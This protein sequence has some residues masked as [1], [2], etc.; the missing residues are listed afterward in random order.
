MR[1]AG[2][3]LS[4]FALAVTLGACGGNGGSSTDTKDAGA[5]GQTGA[6]SLV[7]L[8]KSIGDE[9][10]E[11]SSAH[12][13]ITGKAAGQDITGDGD[14][15]FG[16]DDAA[17]SMDMTTP[18]GSISLVFLDGVLYV[19]L[20]QELQPGKPWLKIDSS[21]NSPVAKAL[22]TVNEQL[23]KNADP[24]AALKE[25]EKSGEITATKEEEL[26]GKKTKHYT[27]TVNVQKMADNQADPTQKKAMQDAIAAG[28]KDFPVDVW[29]DEEGL[30]ARFALDT[31]TPDG[32]G[33]MTSVKMQV[34]YTDWGKP[35]EITPPPADQVGELPA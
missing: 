22:S 26:D 21:S 28:M 24:R 35:V 2:I 3:V 30:P 34:D 17:L 1:K 10:A 6:M 32:S 5:N 18:Q 15:K 33:G 4:A 27:I 7:D 31:P 12:M 14:L 8:A 29:V 20:P 11:K 9:T 16:S 13:K 23:S 19:K 25:F